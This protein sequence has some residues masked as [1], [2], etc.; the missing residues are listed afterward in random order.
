MESNSKPVH[1][2][3]LCKGKAYQTR[4]IWIESRLA[5]VPHL[6]LT[7]PPKT[8]TTNN[9]PQKHNS[10]KCLL[11]RS[12]PAPPEFWTHCFKHSFTDINT[13]GNCER[14]KQALITVCNYTVNLFREKWS[15]LKQALSNPTNTP[16]KQTKKE[17][18]P[19]PPTLKKALSVSPEDQLSVPWF[20]LQLLNGRHAPSTLLQLSCLPQCSFWVLLFP[21][22]RSVAP[23]EGETILL[24]YYYGLKP[25]F[26][27][28]A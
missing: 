12:Y 15:C 9:K 24:L 25:V 27:R 5:K 8:K 3:S 14:H 18:S 16:T 1:L 13:A 22:A 17:S 19:T 21:R 28:Q 11:I 4:G 23:Q 7:P 10:E 2:F 26:V 20:S 6:Y